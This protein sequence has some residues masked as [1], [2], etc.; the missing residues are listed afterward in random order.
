M[1]IPIYQSLEITDI[2]DYLEHLRCD[3][4]RTLMTKQEKIE[5]DMKKIWQTR[6]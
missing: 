1:D 4:P 5:D 3:K 2:I 6:R